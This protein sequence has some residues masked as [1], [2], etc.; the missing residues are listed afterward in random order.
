[1]INHL[2]TMLSLNNG[3]HLVRIGS[4]VL[5]IHACGIEVGNPGKPS[6]ATTEQSAK[7]QTEQ[8]QASVAAL[9]ER[10]HDEALMAAL[11]G[12]ADTSIAAALNLTPP[13][14]DQACEADKDGGVAIE[15]EETGTREGEIGTGIYKRSVTESFTREF[16]AQLKIAKLALKS[17]LKNGNS[18]DATEDEDESPEVKGNDKNDLR[19]RGPQNGISVDWAKVQE[20]NI[21]SE[22][23]RSSERK[24]QNIEK[25]SVSTTSTVTSVGKRNSKLEK[26]SFD[27]TG[28]Q[29]RRTL[30][31]SSNLT[32]QEAGMDKVSTT[33]ASGEPIVIKETYGA[34]SQLE[35]VVLE[36]GT[37]I[38]LNAAGEKILITYKDLALQVGETCQPTSGTVN[39]EVYTSVAD[40]KPSQRFLIVFGA[41]DSVIRFADGQQ[42]TLDFEACPLSSSTVAP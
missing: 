26:I 22:A 30:D 41:I 1:M 13:V 2:R 4:C 36:S 16:K 29:L 32:L 33:V 17:F 7:V 34:N 18:A 21:V 27:T 5:F 37:V 20:L 31:F 23:T 6:P 39:G 42:K 12:Y 14:R 11:E 35:S 9:V 10:Q 38:G 3:R 40:E 24:V 25:E 8:K 19:C 15:Q 28:L